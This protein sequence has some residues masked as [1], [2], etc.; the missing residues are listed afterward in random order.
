MLMLTKIQ[1]S[2]QPA[3]FGGCLTASKESN[4]RKIN[5]YFIAISEWLSGRSWYAAKRI[6]TWESRYVRI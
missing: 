3:P 4:M 1:L 5:Y 6:A 2:N